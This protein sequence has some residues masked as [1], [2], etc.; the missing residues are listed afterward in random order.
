MNLNKKI[1]FGDKK[2]KK[3]VL[4]SGFLKADILLRP[5]WVFSGRH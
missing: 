3:V 4:S 1:V 5:M 2:K